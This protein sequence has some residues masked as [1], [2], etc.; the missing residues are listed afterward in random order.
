V[1]K[2]MRGWFKALAFYKAHPAEASASIA[3]HYN[4]SAAEYAKQLAGLKWIDYQEQQNAAQAGKW[5]EL[6]NAI[7]E[8]KLANQRI[9]EKPEAAQFLNQNLLKT[10]YETD[11]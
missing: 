11:R 2:L 7:A 6:F 3:P 1:R 4:L 10:L 5:V 8:L 9:A